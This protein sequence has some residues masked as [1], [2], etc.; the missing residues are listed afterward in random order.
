MHI[1]LM[2]KYLKIGYTTNFLKS[3]KISFRYFT[4]SKRES[5]KAIFFR[6]L[7]HGEDL[8]LKME[9]LTYTCFTAKWGQTHNL[10]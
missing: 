6:S 1:L 4:T 9:N 3:K 7:C 10:T 2:E 5:T 8:G